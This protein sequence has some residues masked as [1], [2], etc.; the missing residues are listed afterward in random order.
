MQDPHVDRAYAR[1]E[2]L[3]AILSTQLPPAETKK[4]PIVNQVGTLSGDASS[5][6]SL[7]SKGKYATA[8]GILAQI[9]SAFPLDVQFEPEDEKQPVR[10]RSLP[11]ELLV[12][13]L[14]RLDVMA[15][16][17]FALVCRKAR[18]LSLDATLW[19]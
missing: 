1:E 12:F 4:D 9:T 6:V 2:K 17:R 19:R 18:L 7:G 15:I 5:S 13:V 16:E 11:N 8:G 3:T 10:L 14:R